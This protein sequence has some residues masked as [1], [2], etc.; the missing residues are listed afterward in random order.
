MMACL[1]LGIFS[2]K[3]TTLIYYTFSKSHLSSF[4][5]LEFPHVA[6]FSFLTL[7]T[8]PCMTPCPMY[9]F[10]VMQ[11]DKQTVWSAYNTLSPFHSLGPEWQAWYTQWCPRDNYSRA[12][13]VQPSIIRF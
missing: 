6:N 10:Q 7:D 12:S 1:K 13:I 3:K 2:L 5:V 4:I 9:S 8:P 11:V